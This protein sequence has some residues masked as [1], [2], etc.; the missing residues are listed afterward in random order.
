MQSSFYPSVERNYGVPLDTRHGYTKG[1]YSSLPANTADVVGDWECFV[2]AIASTETR[3]MF[4]KDLAVWI[5]ETPTNQAM[6]DLYD[7]MTGDY[8]GITFVA[9]PVMGGAFALL[10]LD[11]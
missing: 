8:P 10:L 3:D 7:T 4:F 9:R 2:A 1:W 11:D 6:T 5:N